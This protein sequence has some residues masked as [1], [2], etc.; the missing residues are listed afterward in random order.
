MLT[1]FVLASG[2]RGR[3]VPIQ[4]AIGEPCRILKPRTQPVAK[5]CIRH[6]QY[7]R[8]P[9][10]Y[11]P[12]VLRISID[13]GSR[14]SK[15][16]ILFTN[17]P[18]SGGHFDRAH[19]HQR[20]LPGDTSKP[21]H[22]ELPITKAGA[23]EFFIEY[24]ASGLLDLDEQ[25]AGGAQGKKGQRVRS[26]SGYFNVDPIL[27]VPKR[28]PILSGSTFASS[29]ATSILP[30]GKGGQ[31]LSETVS[32]PLDGLVIQSVIAKWMGTLDEWKPHL[33]LTRDRGYNMIHF[34]P[35]QQR[36]ESGSP[37][38]IYDQL[39]FDDALFSSPDAL[40]PSQRQAEMKKWLGKIRK[41]WGILN[42]TD[43]VFNHTAN[44]SAWL[45]LHPEAGYNVVNSPHLE[46][47]LEVDTALLAF[48]ES[49]EKRGLPTDIKSS[50]DLDRIGQVLRDQ[51]LP[52]LQLWQYYVIDVQ[53]AK[54]QVKA[55]WSTSSKTD[56]DWKTFD[57]ATKVR[58]FGNRCMKSGWDLLGPRF[59]AA[60]D[61]PSAVAAL[62]AL[63]G[64]SVEAALQELGGILDDL[65]VDR[66]KLY[67]ED[68][69]SILDNTLNRAKYTRLDEHGPKLGP[70]T[71]KCV[72]LVTRLFLR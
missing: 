65:N 27:T 19:F 7:I 62:R 72:P 17:F 33:D 46:G 26:K 60:V 5:R 56:V 49:L 45:E 35:L 68:V 29:G 42:M 71:K 16:G 24:D 61:V 6:S 8:L 14:A 22:V 37:Y 9:P 15:S 21:I 47:A 70:I 57:R 53:G 23:Y 39:L 25:L 31:V 44:N 1:W 3:W 43:V 28:A 48:S 63:T 36:G 55:G 4:G 12:Y 30:V 40:S 52:Q 38:S 11:T 34:T 32:L 18:L 51:V 69:K 10:P 64:D 58:E 13:A 2:A 50:A 54:E 67:D 20:K 66:Y 59:H 41:E